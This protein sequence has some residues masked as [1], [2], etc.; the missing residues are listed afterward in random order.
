[1]NSIF[2][3]ANDVV[4]QDQYTLLVDEKEVDLL[5]HLGTYTEMISDAAKTRAPN[6]V[7]NYIQKLAQYFHSFYGAH[8]INDPSNPEL[9]NERLA[10]V[11]A[12]Q[13][14]LKNALEMI[15]VSSP[16]SM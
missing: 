2:E 5:K 13:I 6:K 8:K 1:M 3:K 11:K 4:P 12:T 16:K 15:G 14:T 7:T 9:S 10:L